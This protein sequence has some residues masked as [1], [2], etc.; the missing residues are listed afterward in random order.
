MTIILNQD[1]CVGPNGML[2]INLA[3]CRRTVKSD[4]QVI[5]ETGDMGIRPEEAPCYVDIDKIL[6]GRL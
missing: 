3:E 2:T 5:Y 6:E 4:G 1:D